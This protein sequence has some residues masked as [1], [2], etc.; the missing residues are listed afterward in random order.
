MMESSHLIVWFYS[1]NLTAK[2]HSVMDNIP[3]LVR[4]LF[5]HEFE[6]SVQSA[7]WFVDNG[8]ESAIL[9]TPVTV[10]GRRVWMTTIILKQETNKNLRLAWW[11]NNVS[12]NKRQRLV[13]NEIVPL[14]KPSPNSSFG[15][16]K[17][18]LLLP[19]PPRWNA[20]PSQAI[21]R[22]LPPPPPPH[23]DN[24]PVLIYIPGWR[25]VLWRWSVFSKNTT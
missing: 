20:T 10:I 25:E 13:S 1:H 9:V 8:D 23:P 15:S 21:Y 12:T 7:D 14:I 22:P 24:I 3:W 5:A 17:R 11:E 6:S 16:M 18:V 4:F 2:H 19:P